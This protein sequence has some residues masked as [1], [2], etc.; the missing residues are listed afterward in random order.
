MDMISLYR[1]PWRWLAG[2]LCLAL[3]ACTAQ[4]TAFIPPKSLPA[5]ATPLS[6]T[7][8]PTA[9]PPASATP[10]LTSTPTVT[11]TPTLAASPTSSASPLPTLLPATPAGDAAIYIY[12]IQT[13]TG[14]DIACGDSAIPLNTGQPRSGNLVQD[15][16][17]ALNQLLVK[18]QYIGGLY[19]PAWLSNI[20]VSEV[21]YKAY[22]QTIYVRLKG[23]YVRSDDRCDNARVRA[24]V[25]STIRQFDG[26]K[27]V[28]ILLND[29]LLG[30][31]LAT[32]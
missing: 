1:S 28:D 5:S 25:W 23:T 32:R 26:I 13:G 19:N 18:R 16:T 24:Q 21:W 8:A 6:T 30:D 14:G 20:T 3:A 29:N 31:I 15:V 9:T 4:P 11:L 10:T 27:V 12:L 17:T 2:L 7:V 22:S